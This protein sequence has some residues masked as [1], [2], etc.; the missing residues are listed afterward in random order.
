MNPDDD[1][2]NGILYIL[3]MMAGLLVTA[4]WV[5]AIGLAVRSLW[6]W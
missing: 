5:A 1:P 4:A 3:G 6:G 2:E